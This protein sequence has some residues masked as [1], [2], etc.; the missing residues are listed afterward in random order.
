[1]ISSQTRGSAS[2]RGSASS[3]RDM[4]SSSTNAPRNRQGSSSTRGQSSPVVSSPTRTTQT[5][6]VNQSIQV[7]TIGDVYQ[8]YKLT[9]INPDNIVLERD[10][11]MEIIPLHEGAKQGQG[12]KTPIVATQVVSIGA[13][14]ISNSRSSMPLP[15]GMGGRTS[16]STGTNTSRNATNG[17]DN[18][19]NNS[20]QGGS[21]SGIQDMI[22]ILGGMDMPTAGTSIMRT[23]LGNTAPAGMPSPGNTLLGPMR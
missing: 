12:G 6:Q 21:P 8:G 11:A 9:Q 13:G 18:R 16:T 15:S 23:L 1:M 19:G 7:M 17:R 4:I 22:Q 5:P 10:Q 14:S 2:N 20:N 3:V